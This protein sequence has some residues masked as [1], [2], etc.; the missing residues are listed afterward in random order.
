MAARNVLVLVD[1]KH[2]HSFESV[3]DA[4]EKG[5]L[6]VEKVMRGLRTITGKLDDKLIEQLRGIDGVAAV[7]EEGTF[8]LPPMDPKTPQ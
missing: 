7:R 5:G 6:R 3:Q 1:T 4:V 2:G 8:S